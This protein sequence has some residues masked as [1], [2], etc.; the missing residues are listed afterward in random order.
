MFFHQLKQRNPRA[1]GTA[2]RAVIGESP[3]TMTRL[4]QEGTTLAGQNWDNPIS[5]P[6]ACINFPQGQVRRILVFLIRVQLYLYT[7]DMCVTIE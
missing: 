3:P 5:P 2:F 1:F 4:A 7:V 6:S